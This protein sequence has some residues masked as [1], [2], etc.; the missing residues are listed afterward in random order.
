MGITMSPHQYFAIFLF[1]VNAAAATADCIRNQNAPTVIYPVDFKCTL[2]VGEL[3]ET[4]YQKFITDLRN[5]AKG[6]ESSGN[7]PIL[8]SYDRA[9]PHLFDVLL[10]NG[11]LE[12]PVRFR[13]DNLY[14]RGYHMATQNQWMEFK[15]D[16]LKMV[17]PKSTFLNF[18]DKYGEMEAAMNPPGTEEKN[19][20]R[21]THLEF[22]QI[23][24]SDVVFKLSKSK[25]KMDQA[26][27]LIYMA[28][29]ISEAARFPY[30]SSF[31]GSQLDRVKDAKHLPDWMRKLQNDWG[32]FSKVVQCSDK[33][34][35]YKYEKVT[36]NK[37]EYKTAEELRG[38]FGLMLKELNL[39]ERTC[40]IK[41]V[42]D[43]DEGEAA[44]VVSADM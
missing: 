13:R 40:G 34:K 8:P 25:D 41:K 18:G 27:S 24:L 28:Q 35:K 30:V 1:A 9:P 36:I 31:F 4:S 44:V 7:I 26:R 5:M 23:K 6:A 29:M 17:D 33:Y 32:K 12:V 3:T 43:E 22:T 38:I 16:G 19:M 42:A 15:I 21:V 11:N 20:I 37:V 14:V 10:R 2:D 39:N